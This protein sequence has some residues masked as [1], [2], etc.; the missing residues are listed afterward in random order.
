M[1]RDR[2]FIRPSEETQEDIPEEE[3]SVIRFE[4]ERLEQ[5]VDPD[6]P[7]CGGAKRGVWMLGF[8]E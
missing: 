2:V 8:V 1:L 4:G 5:W 6:S 3:R 7:E